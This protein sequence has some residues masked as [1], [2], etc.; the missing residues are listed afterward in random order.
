MAEPSVKEAAAQKLAELFKS[1]EVFS[2]SR[3]MVILT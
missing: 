2:D 1:P 3:Q